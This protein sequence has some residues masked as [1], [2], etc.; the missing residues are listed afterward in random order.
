MALII[1]G[2]TECSL[3]GRVISES[4]DVTAFSAFVSNEADELYPFNDASFHKK[5]FEA[6]PRSATCLAVY[7]EV[8]SRLGP[9]HRACDICGN[10][11]EHYNEHFTVGYLSNDSSSPLN[12]FNCFQSHLACFAGSSEAARIHEALTAAFRSG[13]LKGPGIARLIQQIESNL[14]S[15]QLG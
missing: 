8:R 11:I 7:N 13:E 6:D 9:D 12:Q 5:C 4:D 14:P 3:C 1:R 10:D 2:K 15:K